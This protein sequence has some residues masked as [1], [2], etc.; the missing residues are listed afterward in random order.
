MTGMA[1]SL[2]SL[3]HLRNSHPLMATRIRSLA[4]NSLQ[5]SYSSSKFTIG[6]FRMVHLQLATMQLTRWMTMLVGALGMR[7]LLLH[8]RKCRPIW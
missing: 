6:S 3:L 1:S 7:P 2:T 5:N 4:L 8:S